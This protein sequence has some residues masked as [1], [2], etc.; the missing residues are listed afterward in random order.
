MSI[1]PLAGESV[2]LNQATHTHFLPNISMNGLWLAT[3]TNKSASVIYYP[4]C[5]LEP[6]IRHEYINKTEEK[7]EICKNYLAAIWRRVQLKC[8]LEPAC[9][10]AERKAS[11]SELNNA[12]N[13]VEWLTC[14]QTSS[15]FP[16]AKIA[17][18]NIL[19]FMTSS[20]SLLPHFFHDQAW[21]WFHHRHSQLDSTF[22]LAL[23]HLNSAGSQALTNNW[24]WFSSRQESS[25][26]EQP[27]N[28]K[29]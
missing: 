28:F 12:N 26:L 23:C 22:T 15:V 11:I 9:P 25:L 2:S 27:G 18:P 29:F 19:C 24:W 13:F 10:R 5:K 3:K 20:L 17:V 21:V 14:V 7:R 1:H 8:P 16:A 4:V 6:L